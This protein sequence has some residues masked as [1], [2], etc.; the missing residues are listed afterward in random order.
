MAC[1]TLLSGAAQSAAH[2]DPFLYCVH[3]SS[4]EKWNRSIENSPPS[5]LGSC[6]GDLSGVVDL[7]RLPLVSGRI[8]YSF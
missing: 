7:C 5:S 4:T 1:G 6:R 2:C 3:G 8:G